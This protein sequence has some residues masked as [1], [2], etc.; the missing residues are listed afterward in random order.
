VPGTSS[1]TALA[2][3]GALCAGCAHVT[4][5]VP[6]VVTDSTAESRA[7]ILRV[8]RQALH[9]APLTLANDALTRDSTLVVERVQRRDENGVPLVGRDTG[10]PE[11]FR[12]VKDG[13]RCV[14]VHEG[15]GERYP[16]AATTCEAEE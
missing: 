11:R 8:V 2:L 16:L 1:V 3:A 6:A 9:G 13:S 12:L 10:R 15:T 7:E 5:D 4:H 14:L